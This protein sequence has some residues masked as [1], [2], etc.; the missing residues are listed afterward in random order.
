MAQESNIF[1]SNLQD[2]KRGFGLTQEGFQQA[3][4]VRLPKALDR[5]TIVISSPFLRAIQTAQIIQ[6]R[7]KVKKLKDNLDLRERFFGNYD[8]TSSQI[9]ETL[10]EMDKLNS[11]NKHNEVESPNEVAKRLIHLISSLEKVCWNRTI[12]FVSH[13]DPLAILQSVCLGKLAGE[14]GTVSRFKN[15]EIRHISF[16]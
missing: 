10:R 4:I 5:Q 13:G 9:L 11:D 7:L 1:I 3:E 8:K 12:L 6:N 16:G 14:H 15:A 2:G